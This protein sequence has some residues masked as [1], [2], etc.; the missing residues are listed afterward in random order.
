MNAFKKAF[1]CFALLCL[2]VAPA[3]A[4]GDEE[5]LAQMAQ[6]WVAA[7]GAGDVD[8]IAAMYTDDAMFTNADGSRAS[9]VADIKAAFAAVMEQA[10]GSTLTLGESTMTCVDDGI[11]MTDGSWTLD[12]LPDGYAGVTSGRSTV[13]FMPRLAADST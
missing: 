7:W 2:A 1:V 11:C 10:S 12:N 8:T 9:G 4:Q 5:A 3:A 6:D 13:T